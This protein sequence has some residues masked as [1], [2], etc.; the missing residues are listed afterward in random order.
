MRLLFLHGAGGYE[1]DQGLAR[2]LGAELGAELVMPHLPDEDMTVEAWLAPIRRALA[3]LGPD[4]YLVAH[5]FGASI[6]LLALADT[7]AAPGRVTLLAMP[8]WSP[9][10]WDV[11]DF[12]WTLPRSAASVS[13]HH[14]RDDE[15]VPF[16]H[17]ALHAARL[18]G[19]HVTAYPR[20]GHQFVG[21]VPELAA[22]V[23]G[24]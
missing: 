19:A 14:S 21:R 20:G 24:A 10:G 1:D 6:L 17:L 7:S 3:G 13:L 5:S 2:T 16:D 12:H 22:A 23:T 9:Q 8:D 18:P 4:D 15:V 11:E